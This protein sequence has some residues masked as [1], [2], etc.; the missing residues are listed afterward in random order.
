MVVT[1][2]IFKVVMFIKLSYVE[3]NIII[4]LRCV[5]KLL[6]I[7]NKLYNITYFSKHLDR[8]VPTF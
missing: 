4:D 6:P 5:L 7:K 2:L 3:I 8:Q 1:K